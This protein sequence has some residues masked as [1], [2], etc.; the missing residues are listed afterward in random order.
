[1]NTR[2]SKATAVILH[3]SDIF[4]ADR[5]YLLF[6]RDQGKLRAR[7][8]GVRRPRSR[9]AGNLLPY[10]PV[11]L[12]F[13]TGDSGWELIVQ[14]HSSVV[15][16]YPDEP[17][18]FLQ[19]AELIAEAIDKLLPDR[20]PHQNFFEGLVY[21]LERLRERCQGNPDPDTL[22][23]IV[24]ELLFKLLIVMGYQPELEKCVV[25]GEALTPQGL[26]WSS[27]V[28]GVISEAGMRQMTVPSLPLKSARTVVVLRQLAR[29][30]FVAERVSVD[31]DVQR[32]ACRVVFDYL[33]TQIG[34]P[35]KSYSVLGRL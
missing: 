12:E 35:L 20:E 16:G 23:L 28:G 31:T 19:H 1:M 13:V 9:L 18:L 24:A 27:Q 5:T 21:T 34:K 29:P 17:L 15:G 3:T 11:D 7:A 30:E 32:E 14:A 4:D 26:S 8:K 10:V 22:L 6:T 25:T 2:H 33:Q